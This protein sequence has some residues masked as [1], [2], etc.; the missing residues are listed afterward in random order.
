MK[1]S[2]KEL[3]MLRNLPAT[4]WVAREESI[5]AMMSSYEIILEA[6]DVLSDPKY[7]TSTWSKAEALQNK[8]KTF[9]FLVTLMFMKNIMGKTKC[10]TKQ[11]QDIDMNII[12]TIEILNATITT[13]EHIRN[14]SD[15]LDNQILAAKTVAEQ[16]GIDPD[17]EFSRH[18]H[19]RKVPRRIDDQPET[20]ANLGLVDHYRKEFI[21]VLDASKP[22][23]SDEHFSTG[24]DFAQT[25]LP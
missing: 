17:Y 22:R 4:R 10:L 6:F 21:E 5:R 19:V 3:L 8:I 24:P 7:D 16:N 20:A 2:D 12:D 11:V 18:H 25:T 23:G 9:N 1:Q 13:L 14:D 15:G